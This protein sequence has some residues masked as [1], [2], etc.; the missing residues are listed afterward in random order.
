MVFSSWSSSVA[1]LKRQ[2]E[3]FSNVLQCFPT[4]RASHRKS[5][6]FGADLVDYTEDPFLIPGVSAEPKRED[7]IMDDLKFVRVWFTDPELPPEA[8]VWHHDLNDV[9]K[10]IVPLPCQD[11]HKK[12]AD[13]AVDKRGVERI[14]SRY[15]VEKSLLLGSRDPMVLAQ[16]PRDLSLTL[17][18]FQACKQL[19]DAYRDCLAKRDVDDQHRNPLERK[20]DDQGRTW[21]EQRL[22]SIVMELDKLQ[23]SVQ[24]PLTQDA[25]DKGIGDM[26]LAEVQLEDPSNGYAPEY[27]SHRPAGA[28]LVDL[29]VLPEHAE[30]IRSKYLLVEFAPFSGHDPLVWSEPDDDIDLQ[31]AL[32]FRRVLSRYDKAQRIRQSQ[33]RIP[34]P[35]NEL[36]SNWFSKRMMELE[37]RIKTIHGCE[38]IRVW[39][40]SD[41]QYPMANV[42]S[43]G[44]HD[45]VRAAVPLQDPNYRRVAE[46]KAVRPD[47]AILVDL[48]VHE[49]GVRRVVRL[50][51]PTGFFPM[52]DDDPV[53]LSQPGET[54]EDKRVAA[55]E[56]MLER[57]S[58]YFYEDCRLLGPMAKVWVAERLAGIK[59]HLSVIHPIRLETIRICCPKYQSHPWEVIQKLGLGDV[60]KEAVP[61]EV[62]TIFQESVQVDLAIEPGGISSVRRLCE[63]VEFQR[64]SE[65]DPIIQMQPNGDPRMRIF[66]GYNHVLRLYREARALRQLDGD[67]MLWY[68]REIMDL[69]G[70]IGRAGIF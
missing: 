42:R 18:R 22:Q 25:K 17:K 33:G 43:K 37:G 58:R 49:E 35:E 4:S 24:W 28:I 61:L 7:T 54:M 44:L 16:K 69:E 19:L 65:D 20:L 60:V 38:T 51:G 31:R 53:V 23:S 34:E 39:C 32:A 59:I 9:V 56:D 70:H 12:L 10:V 29:A 13:L 50:Y 64:L 68:E 2:A 63:L 11:D 40:C 55:Y 5:E 27:Q 30:T 6:Y 46:D 1:F 48:A 67:L 15:E 66:Y 26:I 21:L 8:D 3:L 57:Y 36:I 14:R 45:V 47:G 62:P 41:Q 52:S